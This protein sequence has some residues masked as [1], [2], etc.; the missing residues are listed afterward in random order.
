MVRYQRLVRYH[1]LFRPPV[2]PERAR[3]EK[4]KLLRIRHDVTSPPLGL[5]R[6]RHP[7]FVVLQLLFY[8]DSRVEIN[9][10]FVI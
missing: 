9:R 8:R 4:C 6:P 2:R 7:I 5:Y 3:I 1:D 10:S